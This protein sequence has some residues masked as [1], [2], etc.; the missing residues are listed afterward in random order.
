MYH[1][2]DPHPPRS[3][4]F[5]LLFRGPL[6]WAAF[7]RLRTDGGGFW[8]IDGTGL[9]DGWL[10]EEDT[11]RG[12]KKKRD[13]GRQGF[14]FKKGEDARVGEGRREKRERKRETEGRGIERDQGESSEG[15]TE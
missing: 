11:N 14:F 10:A 12:M 1:T 9:Q 3:W 7:R 6:K 15:K 4:I 13:I 8:A 2:V 5:L